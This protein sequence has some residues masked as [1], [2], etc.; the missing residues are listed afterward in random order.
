ADREKQ[1]Q[2]EREEEERKEQERL[3]EALRRSEEEARL[4][5]EKEKERK[6]DFIFERLPVEPPITEDNSRLRIRAPD[7]TS[8]ERRFSPSSA[9]RVLLDFLFTKGYS[10]EEYKVLTS[11]PRRD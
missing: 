6:R 4:L 2:K 5:E 11:Y 10:E 7:G 1:A 9:L 3:E 8:L